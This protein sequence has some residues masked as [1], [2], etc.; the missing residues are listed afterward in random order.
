M[1]AAA[2]PIRA[3]LYFTA[4]AVV[5]T[6]LRF[7]S[8]VKEAKKVRKETSGRATVE[9]LDGRADLPPLQPIPAALQPL[10]ELSESLL[11][12]RGGSLRVLLQ[13]PPSSGKTR[14]IRA[15]VAHLGVP[16]LFVRVHS[17]QVEHPELL[18][19]RIKDLSERAEKLAPCIVVLD[20]LDEASAEVLSFMQQHLWNGTSRL[21]WIGTSRT[22]IAGFESVLRIS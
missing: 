14:L 9:R 7:L 17:L 11:R 6:A 3:L 1:R 5:A 15:Y 22:E 2:N 12:L 10:E 4:G 19:S 16:S 20:G 13:G 21:L 18:E 8:H